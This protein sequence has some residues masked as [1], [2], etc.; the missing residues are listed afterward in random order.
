MDQNRGNWSHLILA[1][2]GAWLGTLVERNR[3]GEKRKSRAELVDPEG[4]EDVCAEIGDL[5]EAWVP[6]DNCENEDDFTHDLA[7]HLISN[8]DWE[9]EFYPNTPEGK[10]DI[11]VGDLLAIELKVGLRK[12]ERDRLIGQCAGY[13]RL[14]VTWAVVIDAGANKIGRLVD[15]LED[16]ELDHIGVWS[17]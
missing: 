10:P 17:F 5:L 11:L 15:L 12:G 2:G 7:A 14:W 13:S 4:V 8:S 6:D 16:K 3:V 9:I 1:V